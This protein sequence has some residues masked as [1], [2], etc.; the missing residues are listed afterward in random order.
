MYFAENILEFVAAAEEDLTAFRIMTLAIMLVIEPDHLDIG[1]MLFDD[2][3]SFILKGK[4]LF[5]EIRLLIFV[6]DGDVEIVDLR[7]LEEI[8]DV[9][10]LHLVKIHINFTILNKLLK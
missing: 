5:R 6:D 8:L 10:A 1:L 2:E 3:M 7:L 4:V 9:L